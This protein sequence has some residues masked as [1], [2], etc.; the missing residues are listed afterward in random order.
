MRAGTR[1]GKAMQLMTQVV[2][3]L[4]DEDIVNLVSYMSS[5]DP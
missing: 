4:S 5:R 1:K 2:A 3:N